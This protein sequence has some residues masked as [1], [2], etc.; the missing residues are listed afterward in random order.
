MCSSKFDLH[1]HDGPITALALLYDELYM[2]STSV[3]LIIKISC[4]RS[5]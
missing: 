1:L 4:L 5:R 3:E 2:I